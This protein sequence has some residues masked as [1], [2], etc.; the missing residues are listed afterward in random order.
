MRNSP[1]VSIIINNYN[2]QNFIEQSI[3][4]AL[5]QCYQNIEVIV[6][7]DGSTDN[8]RERIANFND[9]ITTVFKENAGQA[10]TFNI[11][12]KKSRG[13]IICFLDAD[14]L[15]FPNKA[16]S[17]VE[18]L[19]GVEN[20]NLAW[21]YH[22]LLQVQEDGIIDPQ[23]YQPQQPNQETK[24]VHV[25]DFRKHIKN[26]VRPNFVPSTS[27]LCF[28][29]NVLEK[30]LPMP[31]K[32]GIL[33]SDMYLKYVAVFLGK[34]AVFDE[35]LGIYRRHSNNLYATDIKD[36]QKIGAGIDTYT[37]YAFLE[38][39]PGLKKL[40][41]KMSSKALAYYLHHT[42]EL[43]KNKHIIADFFKKIDSFSVIQILIS[44]LYYY[45]KYYFCNL[46]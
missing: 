23:R 30:I 36:K 40:S 37:S 14:D 12:F 33:I 44:T 31:T 28:K 22:Y 26:G 15:C 35:M 42:S 10:S 11:G 46:Y 41:I 39:F 4:S 5:N 43:Q 21:C 18:I 32:D 25:M 17:V 6:V 1:L 13:E 45:F 38:N 27:G 3:S 20:Q 2:Y 19:C 24:K 8:S 16:S 34:G 29:R 7:D 9:S